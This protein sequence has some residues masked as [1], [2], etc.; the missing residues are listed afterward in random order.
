[1]NSLLKNR[2]KLA[3][4][5]AFTF[6]CFA[7]VSMTLVSCMA[8]YEV[9]EVNIELDMANLL[10]ERIA[11]DYLKKV[12]G[13]NE[14]TDEGMLLHFMTTTY[15]PLYP[16][17]SD[18]YVAIKNLKLYCRRRSSDGEIRVI[19][20]NRTDTEAGSKVV[21]QGLDSNLSRKAC[22]ALISLGA[23]LE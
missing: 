1:M 22:T 23:V 6:L 14:L 15:F 20:S 17:Q 11:H 4:D 7:F 18:Q 2:Y 8:T 10:P 3:L 12:V 5:R 21:Y 9:T 19:V 16:K 13:P